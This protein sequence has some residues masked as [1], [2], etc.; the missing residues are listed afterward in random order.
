LNSCCCKNAAE[1]QETL[2]T[3]RREEDSAQW[4]VETFSTTVCTLVEVYSGCWTGF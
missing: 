2:K 3:T 4:F 1:R